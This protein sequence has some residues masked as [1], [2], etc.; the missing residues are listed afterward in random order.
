MVAQTDMTLAGKHFKKAIEL[1]LSMSAD[2]AMAKINLA[3]IAMT[4]NRKREAAQ[5]LKEAKAHDK[6]NM[7][8]DQ[9]KM[10]ET[11]MKRAGNQ[12]KQQFGGGRGRGGSRR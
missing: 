1:G 4:K 8:A 6:Q 9:I 2:L 5:L 7:L 3:G 10:M 12:P 11:N